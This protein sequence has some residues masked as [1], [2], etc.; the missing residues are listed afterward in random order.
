MLYVTGAHNSI[1]MYNGP[2]VLITTRHFVH[3]LK[4]YASTNC[5]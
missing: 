2:D 1:S 5:W 3:N 4:L